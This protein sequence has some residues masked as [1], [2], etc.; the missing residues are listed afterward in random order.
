MVKV[1]KEDLENYNGKLSQKVIEEFYNKFSTVLKK[2]L[3][4]ID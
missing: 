1:L 2:Y 4:F 3:N